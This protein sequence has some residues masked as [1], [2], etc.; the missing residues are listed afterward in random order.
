VDYVELTA[1]VAAADADAASSLL[2]TLADGGAWIETP[3]AQ[4]D[5]ESDAISVNGAPV[6]VHVYLRGADAEANASLG[7]MAL[8]T[9][10]I[11]AVVSV[12]RVAEEDWAESWKEHFHVERVGGRVVVVP[13]WRAHN[14]APGDVV[15]TLDPG[16]AFGTGQHETTRMCIEALE[17]AVRPGARPHAVGDR[18]LDAGCGSGILSLVAAKLGAREVLALDIDDVCVRVTQ[19]N[20]RA[21]GVDGIVRAAQGSLGAAWP[22]DEAPARR[23]DV[24][25]VNIIARVIV[26]L[27][28]ALV[29]ALAA[30]GRLIV[31]GVIEERE[32]E[33]RA[34]LE[35]AGVRIEGVRAMS[36]WRCI[37]AVRR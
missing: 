19:E 16:M 29:D 23:F 34:A 17:R 36:D 14:A 28:P 18:V 9:A 4:P 25:V 26:E 22:F 11:D 33:V 27:A 32:A 10:G 30:G 5:L 24:V 31:S 3:F 13:S 12:R 37:E 21:N 6:R 20:A 7:R 15:V 8:S 1:E 35:A 2:R